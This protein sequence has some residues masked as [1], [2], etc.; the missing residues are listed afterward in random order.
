ML[1]I[2]TFTAYNM[3]GEKCWLGEKYSNCNPYKN[4]CII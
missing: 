3:L 1:K 4:I 2:Y